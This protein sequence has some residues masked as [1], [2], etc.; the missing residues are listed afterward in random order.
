M[1]GIGNMGKKRIRQFGWGLLLTAVI[2]SA[3]VWTALAMTPRS[4]SPEP[5][6][7]DIITIDGLKTFGPLERPAV[8]FYHDRH[9]EALAKLNK[10][11]S[12][13]HETVNDRLSLKFKR[14]EDTGKK[15]V[16]D[17]YHDNCIACHKETATPGK[18]SGP[19]TCGK[20]HIQDGT[21]PAS[22]WQPIGLDKSLH[23]RHVKANDKKCE[24]CHHE[25]NEQTKKLF[26]AKGQ[27]GACVYC[28]KETKEENR[29]AYR[30]ASHIACIGCHRNLTAKKIDAGPVQCKGCHDAAQQA[31]IERRSTHGAQSARRGAGQ[32]R[33]YERRSGT[34]ERPH[35]AGTFR[36]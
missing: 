21:A 1:Q 24:L 13:C 29:I 30:P 5:G 36:S 28:H 33:G 9:T 26:Y 23:Y 2:L 19:V 27:E 35:V 3:G 7:A 25:Y 32:N 10:D 18:P 8:L 22:S 14:L 15:A 31:A 11:C 34:R 4:A 6:R 12:A 16:M 20:C 17:T